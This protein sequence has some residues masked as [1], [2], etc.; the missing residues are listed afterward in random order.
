LAV[1]VTEE[2]ELYWKTGLKASFGSLRDFLSRITAK[3]T[4]LKSS[5]MT[6]WR[7]ILEIS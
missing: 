5:I 2:A 1:Y 4:Q 3:R 7:S 6:T